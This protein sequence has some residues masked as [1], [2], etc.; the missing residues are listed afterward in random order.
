MADAKALA[1]STD[2]GVCGRPLLYDDESTV[3]VCSLCGHEEASLIRCPEGHFVCD[4]C[5]ARPAL[6]V[7]AQVLEDADSVDPIVLLE[8]AMA[9]PS[10]AMH[11]PEH[12]AIVPAAIV[13]AAANAGYPVAEGAQARAIERGRK[14]PGGWCGSHGACGA[15]IGAGIA[16]SVITGATPLRSR[17]RSLALAAT[18]FA[19]SRMLDDQPRCCKHASRV[20]VQAT[21][22]F[23]RERLRIAL[24]VSAPGPCAYTDRNAQCPGR[25][26]GSF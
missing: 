26:C 22:E 6:E 24:P 3:L 1:H 13:A 16:V 11:G 12:H 19:L 18:A 21:V 14:I 20:A 15:A 25:A 7:L 9:H 5:H 23:L 2:C 17:E 8:R 10:V 4:R